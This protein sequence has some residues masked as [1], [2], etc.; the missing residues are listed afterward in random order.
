MTQSDIVDVIL[1]GFYHSVYFLFIY[2]SSKRKTPS[3]NVL[4]KMC[5]EHYIYFRLKLELIVNTI[6]IKSLCLTGGN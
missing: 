4:T 1:G 2:F 3:K 6:F 5:P